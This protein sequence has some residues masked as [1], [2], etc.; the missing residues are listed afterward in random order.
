MERA[1]RSDRKI[2][3]TTY[4][5]GARSRSHTLLTLIVVASAWKD[6]LKNRIFELLESGISIPSQSPWSSAMVPLRMPN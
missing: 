3:Q 4:N 2:F 1:F 6:Q 5:S